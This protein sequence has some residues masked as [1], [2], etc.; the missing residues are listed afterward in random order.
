MPTLFAILLFNYFSLFQHMLPFNNANVAKTKRRK[1]LFLAALCGGWW[2]CRY[3]F[4]GFV[5]GNS[6]Q[7]GKKANEFFFFWYSYT[8]DVVYI[9]YFSYFV[10][11]NLQQ[12]VAVHKTRGSIVFNHLFILF[13]F[14]KKFKK[15]LRK[16][17]WNSKKNF[18]CCKI[19]SFL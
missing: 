5:Y 9:L 10:A 15:T 16:V 7:R 6:G 12:I 14:Y 18:N 8:Y 4:L 13:F 11:C 1:L 2:C 19:L 3:C 17:N